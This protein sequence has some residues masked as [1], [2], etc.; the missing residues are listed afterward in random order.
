MY[1]FSDKSNYSGVEFEESL[2]RVEIYQ[3]AGG[4]PVVQKRK[5]AECATGK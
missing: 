1:L 4:H 5:Y 3:L 2:H